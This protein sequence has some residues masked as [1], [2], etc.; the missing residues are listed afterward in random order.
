MCPALAN[1]FPGVISFSPY[2][3]SAT[4]RVSILLTQ[5]RGLEKLRALPKATWVK[6]GTGIPAQ[7]VSD[8][9]VLTLS[10]PPGLQFSLWSGACG[11]ILTFWNQLSMFVCMW[12]EVFSGDPQIN[13]QR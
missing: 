13:V 2:N 6:R 8:S 5:V 11:G 3:K 1:L 4:V 10:L 12:K 9:R 7:A